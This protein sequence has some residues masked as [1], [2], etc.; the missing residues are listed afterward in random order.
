MKKTTKT[1]SPKSKVH[2]TRA[3]SRPALDWTDIEQKRK[4]FL[5]IMHDVLDDPTLG[6]KYLNSD[7]AARQ[8]FEAKGMKVPAGVKVVFLPTGDTDKE[9]GASAVMELP[10]ASKPR[11]TDD[12]LMELMVANYHIVW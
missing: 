4:V 3:S 1:K 6:Q 10:D 12:E 2:R 8:A 9:A 11:P 5:M 7:A